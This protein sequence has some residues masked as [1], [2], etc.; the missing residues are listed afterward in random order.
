[1]V[2]SISILGSTGSIGTQTLDVIKA[3]K[4][5]F[6]IKSLACSGNIDILESQIKVFSPEFVSVYDKEK[7]GILRERVDISVE[8]GMKGL[9]DVAKTDS[10]LVAAMVGSIG[11]RPVIEAINNGN[12]IILANKETLV[13]AGNIVMGLA[14]KKGVSIIPIDS[15][16]SAIFQCL[17]GEDMASIRKIILTC[18]GGPFREKSFEEMRNA[19][20]QEALS[21]PMWNMGRKISVD[22]ATLMNKGLEVIEANMLFGVGP[23]KIEVVIHPECIVHS[24][25]EFSDASVKALL[26]IPDM[27]L[28]IQYALTYPKRMSACSAGISLPEIGK[29]NFSK[30]DM[31]KFPCLGLAYSAASIG[32]SMPCVMN[33]ANEVA[34]KGFLD[35]KISFSGIPEFVKQEMEKHYLIK[36]PSLDSILEIDERIKSV[37]I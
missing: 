23:D 22:S 33:A 27:K 14:R 12:D 3:H 16:H 5:E 36:N 15:E 18:S 29:L 26:G 28:P 21:H 13:S 20:P 7:A 1:M 17:C 25:V 31:K 4:A 11:I 6:K 35:G 10:S 30:P 24:L 19:S 9:L 32:G 2:K 8:S 34:V 37:Q